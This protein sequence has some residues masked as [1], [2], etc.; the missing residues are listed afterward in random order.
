M[1]DAPDET[2]RLLE[3]VSFA[4]RAHE[5]QRRK[6]GRT[7]YAAHPFRVCLIVRHVFG[8]D[9]PKALMAALLHDTIE[10]TNTDFDDLETLCGRDV[11]EWAAALC[12]DTRLREDEREK[13]YVARL[14]AA[15]WQVKVCKLAD[16][17][18]NLTDSRHLKP[19]QKAK[20]ALR[21]RQYLDALGKD[22][23]AE[24][25]GAYDTVRKLYEDVSVKS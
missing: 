2:R 16:L 10:D 14:V 8:V 5:H 22:V 23:P 21:W 15:P 13:E 12:K 25:R 3:A 18:D 24:A 19:E 20:S 11:A 6:D 4:A 9:D 1:P 7:P 17:Y